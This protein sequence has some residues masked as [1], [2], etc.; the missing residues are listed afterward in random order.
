MDQPERDRT[1]E[2][3]GGGAGIEALT[4]VGAIVLAILGLAGVL[5]I[6]MTAIATIVAGGAL[7]FSSGAI[8]SRMEYLRSHASSRSKFAELG[9]GISAEFLG[10]A[11]GI[12]LG[13][14]ALIGIVP[15]V[16]LP[17]AAIVFGGSLLIGTA[18]TNRLNNYAAFSDAEHSDAERWSR[19][20]VASAAG[21]QTLVG[22]GVITL[23]IL[24]LVHFSW[25]TLT[26]VA[27]I[28]VGGSTLLTGASLT[29]RMHAVLH[30][31]V[32]HW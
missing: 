22:L 10:G 12:I 21:A 27:L 9:G 26:L 1:L 7:L 14:L 28:C 13:V 8:V 11:G 4:G 30:H 23:G 25:M 3:I 19:E 24:A 5:P 20:A 17:V 29:S 2:F 6:Y 18:S 16:L 15:A 32:H 31:H